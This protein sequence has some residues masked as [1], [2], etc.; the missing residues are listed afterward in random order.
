MKSEKAIR[1]G[2]KRHEREHAERALDYDK[3]W[4]DALA[5]ILGWGKDPTLKDPRS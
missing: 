3:G 1:R 2:L 4:A 5:W